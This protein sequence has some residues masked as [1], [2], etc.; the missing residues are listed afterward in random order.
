MDYAHSNG[1][2]EVA[3]KS[4]KIIIYDSTNAD[5]SLNNDLA[6]AFDPDISL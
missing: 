6:D 1:R 3:V 5:G 2:A 4:A